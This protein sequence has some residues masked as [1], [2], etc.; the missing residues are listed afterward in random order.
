MLPQLNKLYQGNNRQGRTMFGQKNHVQDPHLTTQELLNYHK[1]ANEGRIEDIT[2]HIRQK[3]QGNLG[4]KQTYK[5]HLLPS[6]PRCLW[7]VAAF[8]RHSGCPSKFWT[9][10][11]LFENYSKCLIW[12]FQFLAFL[13]TFLSTQFVNVAGYVEWDF[14]CDFQTPCR[15]QSCPDTL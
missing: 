12:I 6:T 10:S 4:S 3:R 14:F 7:N 11:T 15:S 13:M 5:Q 8:K 9:R 1:L 2:A